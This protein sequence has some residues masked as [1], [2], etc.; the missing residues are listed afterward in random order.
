[1]MRGIKI[2]LFVV[3]LL[4]SHGLY[5]RETKQLSLQEK[6][7][8]SDLIFVGTV[9][10]VDRPSSEI[11]GVGE[12]ATVRIER[13]LKGR[14]S[15]REISFVT[16]GFSSELNPLCCAEGKS[17]LFFARDGFDVMEF[18]ESGAF[19][20]RHGRED[21]VSATNGPYSAYPIEN[22]HVVGWSKPDAGSITLEE[23]VRLICKAELSD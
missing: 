23:A 13:Y 1:M 5:G 20:V 16:K 9:V 11:A 17:Y 6:V 2:A 10:S 19:I 7:A 22:G 14:S 3:L 4:L 21:Y 18:G 15:P 12:F 8:A